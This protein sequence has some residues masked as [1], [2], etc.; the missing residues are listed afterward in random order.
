MAKLF[1]KEIEKDGGQKEI[2][3]LKCLKTDIIT[4]GLR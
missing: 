2:D 1:K 4:R 3:L